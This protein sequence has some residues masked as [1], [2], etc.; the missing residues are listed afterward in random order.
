MNVTA[1]SAGFSCSAVSTTSTWTGCDDAVFAEAG[2]EAG[3]DD[4]GSAGASRRFT[5][6]KPA[7]G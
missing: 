5:R 3:A 1:A 6:S 2:A 4:D 7:A